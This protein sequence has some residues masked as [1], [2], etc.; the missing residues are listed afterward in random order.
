LDLL[1]HRP[2]RSS[3][4]LRKFGWAVVRAHEMAQASPV[5]VHWQRI[6]ETAEEFTRR[7]EEIREGLA[8][9]QLLIAVC[10]P[11][12][13]PAMPGVC[14][15]EIPEKCFAILH[16]LRLARFKV[17]R[18]GRGAAKTT[19][20]AGALIAMALEGPPISVLCCREIQHSIR[21]SVH[22]VLRRRI[23]QTGL[24]RFFHVDIRAIRAYN[25]S[26]FDFE[27][28]Y[29]NVDRIKSFE[30]LNVCWV[31]EAASI[32][33]ESWE[34]LEPTLRE[35]GSFFVVNYNPDA[36]DA[37]THQM[38]AVAPRPDAI[39][40]RV[41][42]L[43]N[44][45]LTAPLREAMEYMRA[46]DFDAF[47][48]VWM[49]EPRSH[50][51]AQV[52]RGKFVVEEFEPAADWA[53]PY[54]GAD[55]GF[56]LDP[57]A[58]IRAYVHGPVLYIAREVWGLRV[59][60]DKTPELLDNLGSDARK[61]TLRCDCARPESISFLQ[62]HNYPHAV[63]APKWQNSVTDGI[64]FLRSFERIV[65]HPRC[66]R[67]IEEFRLYSYKVDKLT[68]AVLTDLKPGNDHLIDSLRYAM[69]D[70]IKHRGGLLDFY[71]LEIKKDKE[72]QANAQTDPHHV[73][74]KIDLT[75]G[76]RPLLLERA[77]FGGGRVTDL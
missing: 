53:G 63:A 9:T 2:Y 47:Q 39:V 7:E 77:R 26:T 5:A 14:I 72:A 23:D 1:G 44:P 76:K 57:S 21:S 24:A 59:D 19:S 65:V 37:P 74:Q 73:V 28:L 66:E 4:E 50:S 62:R 30:G 68:G 29:S 18:G 8:E 13:L 11:G 70:L 46:T 75:G 55:F 10:R 61:L 33:A 16:P 6:V 41:T 12:A 43:D 27:G 64:A 17:L 69:A 49:G 48:H 58:G 71:A 51:D 25:G 67:T 34:I 56:S 45:F 15:I 42:Y 3:H 31:E 36:A 32:S 22:K 40:E 60:I 35:P 54:L 38:F 20:I 52:F